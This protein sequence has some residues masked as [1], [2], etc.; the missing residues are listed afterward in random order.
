MASTNTLLEI[1]IL[2]S[3]SKEELE[4]LASLL[5]ERKFK[6]NNHIISKDDDSKS[7]MFL[8]Q[9]KAKVTI[10]SIEG[11]EVILAY[12]RRG[13]FFGELALLTGEDRSADVVALNDCSVLFLSS[14]DFKRHA[15]KFQGLNLAM[16]KELAKRLR[17]A[18]SKIADLALYDVYKRVVNALESIAEKRIINGEDALVIDE[19]PKHQDLASMIGTSREMVTR[20]LKSLEDDAVITIEGKQ[21]I[22]WQTLS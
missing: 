10:S 1:P 15:A 13:E 19:R 12:L 22:L 9:G 21:I 17:A 6:K 18:T 11:K 16:M 8:A 2:A 5:S 4:A 3:L 7:L 20:A 14:E